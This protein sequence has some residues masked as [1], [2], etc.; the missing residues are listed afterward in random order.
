MNTLSNGA[1]P[2]FAC[3][4][5]AR[6]RM[7]EGP[8]LGEY[9]KAMCPGCGRYLKW[10]PKRQ[11]G[12][13]VASVNRVVLLGEI[14]KYGVEVVT[15]GQGSKATFQLILSETGQDGKEHAVFVPCEVWGKRAQNAGELAPGQL[16]LF[17]GKLRKR[18]NAQQ[19]WELVISGF[20][21]TPL[22]AAVGA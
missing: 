2:C 15:V 9:R 22:A 12:R 19:Q 14:G 11:E 6:P 13:M 18:Q 21:L 10:L 3:G 4:L 20:D 16:V 1:L 17:E 7:D 5:V 8:Q